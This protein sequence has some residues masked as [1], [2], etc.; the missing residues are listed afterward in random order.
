MVED[1]GTKPVSVVIV[2]LGR[3]LTLVPVD[4]G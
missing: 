2:S 1:D 3:V 4:L